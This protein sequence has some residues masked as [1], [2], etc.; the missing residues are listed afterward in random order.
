LLGEAVSLL[1]ERHAK[2]AAETTDDEPKTRVR[3]AP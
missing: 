3:Y 1:A 2:V